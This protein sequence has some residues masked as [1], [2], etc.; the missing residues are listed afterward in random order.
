MIANL[1]CIENV[2]QAASPFLF[3]PYLWLNRSAFDWFLL[4][5]S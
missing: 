3:V 2:C 4:C 1:L 5:L